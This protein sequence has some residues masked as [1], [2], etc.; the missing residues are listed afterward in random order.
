MSSTCSTYPKRNS[1]AHPVWCTEDGPFFLFGVKA[2]GRGY[3]ASFTSQPSIM[4][5]SPQLLLF[6]PW[7]KLT[8]GNCS[9]LPIFVT[10]GKTA[11]YTLSDPATLPQHLYLCLSI[12]GAITPSLLQSSDDLYSHCY[13][14]LHA[15]CRTETVRLCPIFLGLFFPHFPSSHG[16]AFEIL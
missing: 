12:T 5:Q 14:T 6:N 11:A 10:A 16:T 13:S 15:S 3:H 8:Y 2:G 4:G 9:G 7:R 1:N